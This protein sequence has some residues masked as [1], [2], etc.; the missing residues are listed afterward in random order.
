MAQT[1]IKVKCTDQ[2]LEFIESPIVAS[3]GFNEDKVMFEFCPLWDGFTKTGVFY[4]NKGEYY[5]SLL[6]EENTCIIPHEVLQNPGKMFFGVFGVNKNNITRTS[7]TVKY[8][9]VQGAITEDAKPSDPTPD[10]YEQIL[11]K[12]NATVLNIANIEESDEDGG[13]NVVTFTN[14]DTMTVK[15]GH[16][17]STGAD[18]TSV[19]IVSISQSVEDGGSNIVTFSDGSML[20]VKNGSAGASITVDTELSEESENPVQNKV[21]T[22]QFNAAL[23]GVEQSIMTLYTA[24]ASALATPSSVD[25]SG[26]E[27]GRIVE[28]FADGST[29]TTTIEFDTNGNPTKITDGDGR[30][31]T[32]VW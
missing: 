32:Y 23:D 1:T 18:G 29:K 16:K 15:N 30:V 12:L 6:D 8:K 3:G 19:S 31:T 9:I 24:M 21:I 28:T 22:S 25:M 17:G 14:G 2:M 27:S 11:A 4:V 7:E 26:F 20:T 10:I 13:S 5:E